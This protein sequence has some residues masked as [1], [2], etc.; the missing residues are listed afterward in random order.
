MTKA[1]IKKSVVI[2]IHA[3]IGWLLCGMA[4]D[5][6]KCVSSS[7]NALIAYAIIVSIIFAII[8]LI[9]FKKFN[10]TT[11]LQTAIIFVCFMVFMDI[12]M[13]VLIIEKSFEMFTSILGMWIPLILI[14]A[15]TYLTGLYTQK[16]NK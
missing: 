6:C 4:I 2:L 14:F 3:F 13:V 15:S 9:Y 11:P 10:Y 16:G 1:K 12:F 8:S 7:K 5:I